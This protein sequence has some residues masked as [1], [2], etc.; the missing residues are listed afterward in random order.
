VWSVGSAASYLS[1]NPREVHFGLGLADRVVEIE[2]WWPS[3][4]VD[5]VT[6]VGVDQRIVIHEGQSGAFH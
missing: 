6:N 2:I 4:V 5:R 1:A 3:G